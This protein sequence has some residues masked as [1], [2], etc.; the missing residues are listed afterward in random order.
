MCNIFYGSLRNFHSQLQVF[1]DIWT[2]GQVAL[3]LPDWVS[4]EL[5]ALNIAQV[6][7][8]FFESGMGLWAAHAAVF[9]VST[10]L[11]HFATTGRKDS[12]AC[13]SMIEAFTTS[14][15]GVIMR[16]FLDAI[17]QTQG[18]PR[19]GD[20]PNTFV[21][22]GV[23]ITSPS[24]GIYL[25]S[26]SRADGCYTTLASTVVVVPPSE[27]WSAR[28]VR[29][30]YQSEPFQYQDLN[31]KCQPANSSVYWI[32][33][34][35]GNDCYQQ[36]P[37]VAYF[38]GEYEFGQEQYYP[39]KYGPPLTI[40]PD[41]R[42]Y[43]LPP[44]TMTDWANSIFHT[45]GCEIQVN[46]VWDPPRALLPGTT[47]LT[48]VV[49]WG[50]ATSTTAVST[51]SASPAEVEHS[52]LAETTASRV[53]STASAVADNLGSVQRSRTESSGLTTVVVTSKI[54]AGIILLGRRVSR[55]SNT[56]HSLNGFRCGDFHGG[57][58]ER[59]TFGG[60]VHVHRWY[61]GYAVG[62]YTWAYYR[63]FKHACFRTYRSEDIFIRLFTCY[64]FI[65]EIFACGIFTY[66]VPRPGCR[67][68]DLKKLSIASPDD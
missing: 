15:T 22:G 51:S 68:R 14:K 50:T 19:T 31:Y 30:L 6:A 36:V 5:P 3:T 35:P 43:I 56:K 66:G 39:T 37:A 60:P 52:Q 45:S 8:H 17:V 34:E 58:G 49:A 46:G 65:R 26:V 55:G 41:Y 53:I 9:P 33:N 32:Q 27:V 44:A 18:L 23:T 4:P 7:H 28:G 13:R 47:V 57:I 11:R 64:I 54:R 67:A 59:V 2:L 42:P 12:P 16:D 40:G 38:M 10:A 62:R 1:M 25:A 24:V 20:G 61:T 29:A 21:T 63:A 48:P